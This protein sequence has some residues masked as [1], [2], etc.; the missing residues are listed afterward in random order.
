MHHRARCLLSGSG[1]YCFD[2]IATHTNVSVDHR[3]D[4]AV[5]FVV[6]NCSPDNIPY[7]LRQS[8]KGFGN[9]AMR[10]S[11]PIRFTPLPATDG[12]PAPQAG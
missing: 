7:N 10:L 9:Q 12:A 1:E 3:V 5:R 8:P 4:S 11:A 2:L 6:D